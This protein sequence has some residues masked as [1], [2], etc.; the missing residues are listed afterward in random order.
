METLW[1]ILFLGIVYNIGI[2]LLLKRKAENG[3]RFSFGPLLKRPVIAF[4]NTFIAKGSS[5]KNAMRCRNNSE[6]R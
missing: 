6:G 2:T 3:R 1:T 5:N 4:P